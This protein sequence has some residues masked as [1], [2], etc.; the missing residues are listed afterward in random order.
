MLPVY[1]DCPFLIGPYVFSYVI[2]GGPNG[3]YAV[4]EKQIKIVFLNMQGIFYYI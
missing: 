2:L 1:L 4:N 3:R